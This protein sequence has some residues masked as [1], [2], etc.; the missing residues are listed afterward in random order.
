LCWWPQRVEISVL[1][2]Y[3]KGTWR[4]GIDR[5]GSPPSMPLPQTGSKRRTY[6]CSLCLPRKGH[7]VMV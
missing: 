7:G 4:D 1:S 6:V 2:A 3:P 5:W